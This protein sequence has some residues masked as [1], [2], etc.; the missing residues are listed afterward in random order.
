[1]RYQ[2]ESYFTCSLPCVYR[3]DDLEDKKRGQ[4]YGLE[5]VDVV[6]ERLLSTALDL[7]NT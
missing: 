4:N 2:L 6:N 3:C 5:Q 1:M 7:R